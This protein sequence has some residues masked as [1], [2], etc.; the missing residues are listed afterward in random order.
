LE[1][2][3][4]VEVGKL[5]TPAVTVPSTHTISKIVGVLKEKNC[6]EV[7]ISGRDK[8]GIVTVRDILK[9]SH[10]TTTKTSSIMKYPTSLS[11]STSLGDAARI[12]TDYRLRALPIVE[13]RELTGALTARKILEFLLEKGSLNLQVKSLTRGSLTTISEN[14]TVAKARNLMVDKKID[15]LPVISDKKIAGIVTSNEIVF[16]LIPRERIAIAMP[17]TRGAQKNLGYQASSI[18]ESP[19]TCEAKDKASEALANMLRA[20]KTYNLVTVLGMVQSIVTPRDYI[21]LI[22]EPRPIVEIPVYIIG[23]PEDPFEAEVA[24]SKFLNAVGTLKRIFPEIEE[25]RSVIK[26]SESVKGKERRRY[27]VDIAM[28][29]RKGVINYTHSG[30]ELPSIYDELATRIKRLMTQRRGIAKRYLRKGQKT[31]K[32]R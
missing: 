3:K 16:R 14:D 24:K 19:L 9:V 30:W 15:H 5:Q 22:A 12:L 27:E 7:F 6:Y 2:L 18:M 31:K 8:V 13:E 23:L 4:K 26:I 17:S 28:T 20:D 25:A 21:N 11:P 10:P 29:T 1:D 32:R